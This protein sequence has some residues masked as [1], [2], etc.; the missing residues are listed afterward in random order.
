MAVLLVLI[1]ISSATRYS[2]VPRSSPLPPTHLVS[3]STQSIFAFGSATYFG[4]T[5]S[6]L[7]NYP[8][9]GIAATADGKGYWEVASDGG[10]FS[11]GDAAFYGSMGATILNRPV[12]GIA[13][14]ADGKG[15]W[16][17][18]SD[19][20]IFSFGDAV[21]YGSEGG[22]PLAHP[23]VGIA[24]I[25]GGGGYLLGTQGSYNSPP[26][27]V[28]FVQTPG[29]L[30]G[31]WNPIGPTLQ[32]APVEFTTDLVPS[33]GFA[34]VSVVLI[35]QGQTKTALYAGYDQPSGNWTYSTEIAPILRPSLV[36]SFNSGFRLDASQG[37]FYTDGQAQVPLDNGAASFV[38]RSDGSATVGQ[39]G[40][41]VAMAANVSQVRQNLTLLVDGGRATSN[42]GNVF[43]WGVTVGGVT[44]TWRSGIGIDQYGDLIYA[45]GPNLN[46]SQL[47]SV[48]IAAGVT[49]GMQLDINPSFPL[50]SSY[51]NGNP[52]K[53]RPDMF[54]PADHYFSSTERDFF[55]IFGS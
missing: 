50:F 48:M 3:S 51:V 26:P 46:P 41:D 33:P 28:P 5:G 44:N 47:A 12:V 27:L 21:S 49:E 17:V 36:A 40:R 37:G 13:A 22:S 16:E 30:Q 32:G 2:G 15:Y 42:V 29:Y 52:M 45:A 39:W 18:A 53:L 55:A 19:G 43:A 24:T 14:T 1:G 23:V 9:V 35:E 25:V 6:M 8:V 38:I 11:F 20:G 7:L 31:H 10:I 34:P 4:S 54:F